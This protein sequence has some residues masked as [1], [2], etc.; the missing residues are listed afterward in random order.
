MLSV[1]V[2]EFSQIWFQEIILVAMFDVFDNPYY[3]FQDPIFDI[4]QET[5]LSDQDQNLGYGPNSSMINLGSI[6]VYITFYFG[7]LLEY[8]I[9]KTVASLIC[10]K[11]RGQKKYL[12][13]K[14]QLFWGQFIELS[15]DGYLDFLICGWI[16]LTAPKKVQESKQWGDVLSKYYAVYILAVGAIIIPLMLVNLY[17]KSIKT[18][19]STPFETKWGALYEGIKTK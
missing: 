4:S 1:K 17:R 11:G 18:I 5:N 2:P 13:M 15:L 3:N 16:N 9:V 19:Q 10:C 7:K 6:T 8:L 12:K 14:K